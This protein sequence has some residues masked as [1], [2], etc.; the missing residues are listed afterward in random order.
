VT[1]KFTPDEDGVT[2]KVSGGFY[3]TVPGGSPRPAVWSG[4]A[5]GSPI[6]HATGGG[7]VVIE[8]ICGPFEKLGPETFAVRF[9][10]SGAA[11][12]TRALELVFA[13]VH[14]G[15]AE[16]KPAVQQ[17]HMMIP[18]RNAEGA[19]Q[20]TTFLEIPDQP[21][22][23]KSVKLRATSDSGAKVYYYVLAG[24]A[25]V[26]GAELKLL[27]VPPRSRFPVKVTVVAW[28]YG[29]AKDPK[30]KTAEPVERSFY[31]TK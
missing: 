31:L 22:D 14:P 27:P 11:G 15:D 13:A 5:A 10:R 24:P 28:Q 29:R 25:E 6:G 1:L 18:A 2:F 17:G 16:Y 20:K 12:G 26:D 3:D 23:T 4:L 9:N 21:L 19:E 7:P 8:R 30:L